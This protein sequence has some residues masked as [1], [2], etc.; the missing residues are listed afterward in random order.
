M[1]NLTAAVG[2]YY[3][4][5]SWGNVICAPLALEAG[6]RSVYFLAKG[7]IYNVGSK[8]EEMKD[9]A[10]QRARQSVLVAREMHPEEEGDAAQGAPKLYNSDRS[11]L[12]LEENVPASKAVR[13]H[14][15][16]IGAYHTC[17]VELLNTFVFFLGATSPIGGILV[18]FGLIIHDVTKLNRAESRD[19]NLD[20]ELVS[21]RYFVARF[22]D[23]TLTPIRH[24]AGGV[25]AGLTNALQVSRLTATIAVTVLAA[26]AIIATTGIP[27]IALLTIV[28]I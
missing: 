11:T 3:R 25:L 20:S 18:P 19:F 1:N 12:I 17:G 21:R 22:A 24:I 5:H 6:A 27:A 26:G 23:W 2:S 8:F 4:S 10:R 15:T 7:L 16:S 28:L 13:Y 14:E 9:N